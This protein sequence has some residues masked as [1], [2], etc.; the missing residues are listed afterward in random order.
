M[1]VPAAATTS[2]TV[3]L[4]L[5][6]ALLTAVT[7]FSVDMY[8]SAF[9]AIAGEFG[10]SASTVQLSLTAFLVGLAVGQLFIGQLSDRLGRRRPLL[11]GTVVC[12]AASVACALSPSIEILIALRFVQ[13]FAGAAGVVIARAIIADRAHGAAAARLFSVMMVIGVLAPIVAPILGGQVVAGFGWRAVFVA[14]A[15][16]NLVM[17]LGAYLMAGESLPVHARRPAGLRAFARSA[18]SVL[19]NRRFMGYTLTIGCASAAMF[20]YISASPFVLQNILGMSPR[21]YSLTFG[22]CALAVAASGVVSARLVRIVAP[23]T[24][25]V[26]GICAMLVI[27]ALQLVNVTV[28]GVLPWATIALMACFM[29][30]LGFIYAN[31]TTLAIAEVRHA[32]GTGSAV[33]GFLQYSLGAAAS[34]LVGLAGE[35]SAVPM[36]AVMFG[37]AALAAVML[38][39]LARGA[40]IP[41][42]E[43]VEA[44]SL[45]SAGG[46][47]SR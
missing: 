25:L 18:F 1:R 5:V 41:R 28:G 24:L 10:T 46:T 9:P 23:R 27:S 3:P 39:G 4:V 36:G 44:V 38:F 32:A 7:P 43:E 35:H 31:G 19:G 15:A 47:T 26:G 40:A 2:P 30:T 33:L 34:P 8:M 6:L 29:G 37:G 21:T 12:L 42:D 22:A 14:L 16:L 45:V 20:G 17:L 11:V 13:G